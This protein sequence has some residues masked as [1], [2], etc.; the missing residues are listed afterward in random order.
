M[1]ENLAPLKKDFLAPGCQNFTGRMVDLFNYL[2]IFDHNVTQ[3]EIKCLSGLNQKHLTAFVDNLLFK[4]WS[5]LKIM[6]YLFTYQYLWNELFLRFKITFEYG[7]PVAKNITL[8][9]VIRLL[10]EDQTPLGFG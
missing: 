9:F 2:L 10:E 6:K 1:L 5:V 7:F 3:H 4:K 8:L